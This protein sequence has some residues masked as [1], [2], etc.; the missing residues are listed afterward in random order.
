MEWEIEQGKHYERKTQASSHPFSLPCL[1]AHPRCDPP[2][3]WCPHS[4][5]SCCSTNQSPCQLSCS[6]PCQ[7]RCPR[8]KGCDLSGKLIWK[9][10]SGS[11][12]SVFGTARGLGCPVR[13]LRCSYG[14]SS[15]VTA[16]AGQ[17]E[18]VILLRF[19]VPSVRL[20]G[21]SPTAQTDL[22]W[23]LSKLPDFPPPTSISLRQALGVSADLD[24]GKVFPGRGTGRSVGNVPAD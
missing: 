17:K 18:I 2:L 9:V 23:R 4:S 7:A 21:L 20:S 22:P 24:M 16:W 12:F 8:P 11:C 10:N 14:M 1:A 6:V 15:Q 5:V 19:H 3:P 13:G